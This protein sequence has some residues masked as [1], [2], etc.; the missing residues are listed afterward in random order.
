MPNTRYLQYI[1]NW[2]TIIM[3]KLAVHRASRKLPIF[4]AY[5]WWS[6]GDLLAI[7]RRSVINMPV[8]CRQSANR[9]PVICQQIAGWAI[10]PLTDNAQY[11]LRHYHLASVISHS[12]IE[13]LSVLFLWAEKNLHDTQVCLTLICFVRWKKIFFSWELWESPKSLFC[14]IYV[15]AV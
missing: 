8:I 1:S 12:F 7:C 5:F 13:V 10:E 15:I 11:M 4:A 14:A 9:L 2:T 6:A 3:C